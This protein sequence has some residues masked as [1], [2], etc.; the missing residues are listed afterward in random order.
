MY[1][2]NSYPSTFKTRIRDKLDQANIN[3]RMIYRGLEGISPWLKRYYSN[4]N[5]NK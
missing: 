3:E 5:P 4:L 2:K 1:I